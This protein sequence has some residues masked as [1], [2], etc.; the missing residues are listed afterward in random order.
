M[1]L[2]EDR[3]KVTRQLE[4][5]VY[6]HAVG[7]FTGRPRSDSGNAVDSSSS[8]LTRPPLFTGN[9]ELVAQTAHGVYL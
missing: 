5:L 3:A 2:P 4:Q 8:S 9:T 1:G 7:S 6:A